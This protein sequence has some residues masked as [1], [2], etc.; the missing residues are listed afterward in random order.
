MYSGFEFVAT[1]VWYYET[2]KDNKFDI[3]YLHNNI[4]LYGYI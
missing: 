3:I 2:R 4:C 1:F